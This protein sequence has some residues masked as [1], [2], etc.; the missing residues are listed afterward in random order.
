MGGQV[1]VGQRCERPATARP[2][3]RRTSRGSRRASRARPALG[4]EIER[5]AV[6]DPRQLRRPD[7]A[8]AS[9]PPQLD[10]VEREQR[11][12]QQRRRRRSRPA[13]ANEVPL[14]RRRP[15]RPRPDRGGAAR[16]LGEQAAAGRRRAACPADRGSCSGEMS[17]T[18]QPTPRRYSS[19]QAC[20]SPPRIRIDEPRR[21][22]ACDRVADAD[23]RRDAG[24]APQVHRGV[25]EVHAVADAVAEQEVGGR[26][27]RRRRA[28]AWSSTIVFSS[29]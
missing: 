1:Q 20:A 17:S 5:R 28:G 11:R 8:G 14:A 21:L 27:G 13:R 16:Q 10:R 26:I 12:S 23:A 2:R 22:S 25:G 3:G 19:G 29:R 15:A 4:Q 7:E 24:R 18:T 9:A 6:A